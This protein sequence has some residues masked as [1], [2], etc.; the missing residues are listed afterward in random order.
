[1][2]E[3][4][5]RR[6]VRALAAATLLI[7]S[8]LP[9][10]VAAAPSAAA[11][12]SLDHVF[13]IMLENHSYDSIIGDS[14]APYFNQLANHYALATSYYGI[15]HPS[16][17]NYIAATSGHNWWLNNDDPDNRVDHRNIVDELEANNV[18]WG[19]YMDAM[20]S[21]GFTG[22]SANGGLYVNRHNPF[23][24]YT[25]VRDDSARRQ[26]IKPYTSLSD[27]LNGR[28]GTIPRY[29]WISPDICNDMHGGVDTAVPGH[30]ESPCPLADSKDD[31]NDIALKSKAE[32]F[33]RK[34]VDTITASQ[35][36]NNG[37]TNAIVIVPDESDAFGPDS[38]GGY[39]DTHYCCDSPITPAGDP[40]ISPDWPGGHYGGGHIPAIVISKNGPRNFKDDSDYNHYALLQ[41][42][43]DGFGLN[44]LALTADTNRVH[45][46]W[47][48]I[49]P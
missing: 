14:H 1:M 8:V 38:T 29:V 36:W 23:M 12:P 10:V 26:H 41:T 44:R 40:D 18:P 5:R 13:V 43:E 34:A 31:A 16:E 11:N 25:D 6:G 9:S 21:T 4:R 48:L 22:N 20:P 17:P 3:R 37:S 49:L 42:I 28:N 32:T 19:A 27:D 39:A 47:P 35:A 7:G 15:T 30:P 33:V 45:P 2:S 46:M 24:L